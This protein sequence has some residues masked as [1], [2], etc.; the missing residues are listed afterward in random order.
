VISWEDAVSV[1]L[2]DSSKGFDITPLKKKEL[3]DKICSAIR[4][5]PC[6]LHA[7]AHAAAHFVG[8][9]GAQQ[10]TSTQRTLLMCFNNVRHAA[11]IQGVH[12]HIILPVSL[13]SLL[14]FQIRSVS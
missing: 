6:S 8:V 7:C 9:S 10:W 13:R 14:R 2:G 4:K 5:V 3:T 1:M 11:G 12:A